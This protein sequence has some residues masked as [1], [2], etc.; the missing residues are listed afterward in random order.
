MPTVVKFRSHALSVAR[1]KGKLKGKFPQLAGR[2]TV[3]MAVAPP[4]ANQTMGP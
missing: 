2:L 4:S 3:A 1:T